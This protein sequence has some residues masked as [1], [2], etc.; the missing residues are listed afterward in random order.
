MFNDALGEA[1]LSINEKLV[2]HVGVSYYLCKADF[3]GMRLRLKHGK[4]TNP[5]IKAST[6]PSLAKTN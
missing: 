3:L 2:G 6:E 1:I 4:K 5:S